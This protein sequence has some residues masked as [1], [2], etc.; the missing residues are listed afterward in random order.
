MLSLFGTDGTGRQVALSQP[1]LGKQQF[2]DEASV[3]HGQN[4]ERAEKHEEA[5]EHIL[6]GDVVDKIALEVRLDGDRRR[7]CSRRQ[8]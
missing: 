1:A 4:D 7:P 3:E 2:T 6:V 5:V 8:V